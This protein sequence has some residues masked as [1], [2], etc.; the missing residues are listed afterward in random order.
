MSTYFSLA[1][2]PQCYYSLETRVAK[3][4]LL[5]TGCK[6]VSCQGLTAVNGSLSNT[7]SLF[8]PTQRT[9]FDFDLI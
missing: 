3:A 8:H 6:R 1:R 5:V 7:P 2:P 9:D 4:R